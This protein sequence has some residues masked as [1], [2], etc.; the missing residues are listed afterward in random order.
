MREEQEVKKVPPETQ[1][2]KDL[3]KGPT[4]KGV[5]AMRGEE[6]VEAKATP[7]PTPP[8]HDIPNPSQKGSDFE[9]WARQE[10]FEGKAR[11]IT[12]L[13]EDNPKLDRL[14]DGVGI[15]KE[16]RIA[17]AYWKEDGSIWELK[18]GYKKGGIDQDQLYEYS[19]ME[20]AGSVNVRVG[21][22]KEK[23]PVTSVNYL[24]DSKAGAKANQ[25]GAA[26]FWYVDEKGKV[27][28]LDS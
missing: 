28:L 11:R 4:P 16:R 10:L 6:T 3:E 9:N 18:S 22:R 14:A 2:G 23:L 26:T 12:I 5:A 17:D 21:G 27:K 15:S 1:S 13:P 8:A 7:S 24:F 20:E 19:L 25:S